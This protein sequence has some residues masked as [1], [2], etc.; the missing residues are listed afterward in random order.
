MNTFM[1]FHY[2]HEGIEYVDAYPV[3]KEM[4]MK[5][6]TYLPMDVQYT[7]VLAE[8]KNQARK[9]GYK[10]WVEPAGKGFYKM[11]L[12]P[13]ALMLGLFYA[14]ACTYAINDYI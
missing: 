10:L 1:V 14:L 8:S 4:N 5:L 7:Y 13:T 9:Q 6:D 3:H 11:P 12:S 2:R